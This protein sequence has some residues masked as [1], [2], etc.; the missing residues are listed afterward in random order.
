VRLALTHTAG[1]HTQ[2]TLALLVYSVYD[3]AVLHTHHTPCD[4]VPQHSALQWV[5]VE[6]PGVPSQ[7]LDMLDQMPA[8]TPLRSAIDDKPTW[9]GAAQH[10]AR[11]SEPPPSHGMATGTGVLAQVPALAHGA[12]ASQLSLLVCAD[13]PGRLGVWLDGTVPLHAPELV[14]G[15]VLSLAATPHDASLLLAREDTLHIH[16]LPLAWDDALVHLARLSTAA[17]ASFVH[18]MDAAFHASQAYHLLV[19]PRCDEWRAHWDD[20]AARHGV[21]LVHEWMALVVGGRASPACEHLL[22]QLTE[23]TTLAMETDAKRGLKSLRRLVA[24][25]VLPACERLLVLLTELLGCA[26]WPTQYPGI[27]EECVRSLQC[28]VQTCHAVALAV[29]EHAERELLSL[30]EFYKWFRMEQD[31]QERLK[32]EEAAPRVVTYHDTLTVL[33]YLQ[34]GFLS[35]AL[36]AML[37]SGTPPPPPAADT[38]DDS[39]AAIEPL[40]ETAYVAY[41][42]D[43]PAQEADAAA[44]VQAALAWLEQ[45]AAPRAPSEAQWQGVHGPASLL[46]GPAHTFRP[47]TLPGDEATLPVRLADVAEAWGALLRG[48]LAQARPTTAHTHMAMPVPGGLRLRDETVR[49]VP[50]PAPPT[51]SG[52][53]ERPL[54][55]AAAHDGQHVHTFVS[56]A[57][58]VSVH[59]ALGPTPGACAPVS[60][61]VPARVHDLALVRGHLHVL[62]EQGADTSVGSLGPTRAP[63]WPPSDTSAAHG[64]GSLAAFAHGTRVLL[65]HDRRTVTVLPL[66]I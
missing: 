63:V 6:A 56:D 57:H 55:R 43:A 2:H 53:K 38:S 48:A 66:P 52:G 9:L 44:A 17:R 62:Y 1:T 29:Q 35:P 45:P 31:R 4:A 34:R 33:E 19:R 16:H 61:A 47:P 60:L 32:L 12:Q 14:P 30:D 24:T 40:W 8:L 5:A 15:A 58:V 28:R 54:V 22:V 65:G 59:V 49:S 26:R 11:P 3:G 64:T 51:M 20:A 13:D 46:G 39:H 23:G 36:D 50:R 18:A 41:E 25:G 7:A 37:G 10:R 21:D 27:D 42:T